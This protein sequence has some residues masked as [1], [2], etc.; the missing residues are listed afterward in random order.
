AYYL[1]LRKNSRLTLN[2]A[3]IGLTST[4][5]LFVFKHIFQR[6]RPVDPLV[7]NL[8][9]Y[10]FPSGHSFSAFTFFGLLIYILWQT[11]MQKAW[12]WVLSIV[13]FLI[14]AF[15][16]T[17]RVYLHAHFASDVIAGFCLSTMWLIISLWILGIIDKK[18]NLK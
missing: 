3:S 4:A 9:G 15:I 18:F 1:F 17:S 13:C 6:T 11:K 5:L 12:K 16:A 14:A 8:V 7:K 10:S 2:V